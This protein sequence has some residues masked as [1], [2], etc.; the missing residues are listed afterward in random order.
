MVFSNEVIWKAQKI[1]F[2]IISTCENYLWK[3]EII[4]TWFLQ[5]VF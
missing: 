2:Q 5:A 3:F 4:S 1:K